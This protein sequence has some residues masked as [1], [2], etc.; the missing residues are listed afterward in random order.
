MRCVKL[1]LPPLERARWLLTTTRLSM[2]SLAG[3]AR[4]LVA[5]G[6]V[7]ETSM[8]ATTREDAPR[9]GVTTSSLTGPV[10]LTAG[11][12]RGFGAAGSV[13][14]S[15][16]GSVLGSAFASGVFAATGAGGAGAAA[17]AGFVAV[18]GAVFVADGVAEPLLGP[19]ADPLD[20]TV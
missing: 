20:G 6:T 17:G 7:S 19:F 12:S 8:L 10:P 3:T 14:G 16:F 13:L 18:F 5:V 2:S 9:S 1:T 4:T 11:M 15:V